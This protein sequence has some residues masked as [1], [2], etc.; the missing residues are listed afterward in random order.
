MGELRIAYDPDDEWIGEITVSV[1]SG[2]FSGAASAWIGV[3]DIRDFAKSLD[4]YPIP[5]EQPALIEAGS[6]GTLD[7]RLPPQMLIRVSVRPHG[8]RGDLLVRVE[9]NTKV[10]T[11]QS[12]DLHQAV[13]AQFLTEY[14]LLERF[15][16]GLEGLASNRTREAVLKGKV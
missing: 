15:A 10:W 9:L 11:D 3:S 6:G 12:S 7:G 1:A 13:S 5:A 16:R 4:Q 14:A 8:T 2:P